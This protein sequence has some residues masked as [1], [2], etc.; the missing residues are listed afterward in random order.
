MKQKKRNKGRIRLR[1]V[2][3]FSVGTLHGM[4]NRALLRMLLLDG[5]FDVECHIA[6]SALEF[7]KRTEGASAVSRWR[8]LAVNGGAGHP[9]MLLRYLVSAFHNLRILCSSRR[10]DILFFNFNNLFSLRLTDVLCRV[11]RRR[12]VICC[13]GEM[14]YLANASKHTRLYKRLMISLTQGYFNNRRRPAPGLRFIVF[15][16]VIRENLRPY[17]SR[18][19]MAALHSVD[20]PVMA[21]GGF[22]ESGH[23]SCG[24]CVDI[25]MAGIIN[26]Y[27]GADAYPPLA[28]SLR[29]DPRLRFHA[30]G[31]F[32]C[33]PEPF[34]D[35][36]IEVPAD[37]SRPLPDHVFRR[38]IENLDFLLFLYPT[39]TYRL[40]A[41]G[42]I[43]DSLRFRRPAI[44]LR[45]D[46]F[47]YLFRKF[48][49]F[50]Y[51]ADN[52]EELRRL[53]RRSP[54]LAK[55]FPFDGIAARLSPESLSPRL[56]AVLDTL[57]IV[58]R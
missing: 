14:E 41:S 42:A 38:E 30:I 46:Y 37:P 7:M 2:S 36:G 52:E 50:G 51:L 19:L 27:K 54:E 47:D 57:D 49:T 31:H 56:S 44:G 6:S 12:A 34:R 40:I 32:Q 13:H 43:L 29:D 1:Y 24:E 22:A 3:S 23:G 53:L 26:A 39:D 55:D 48:G 18:E 21:A 17:L 8:K 33:D 11:L 28:G 45:T 10:T 5:R 15:G 16:D 25:G 35:A 9:A 20:H 4:I 58:R